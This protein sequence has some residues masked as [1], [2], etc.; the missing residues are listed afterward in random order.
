MWRVVLLAMLP[1][2]IPI[3]GTYIYEEYKPNPSLLESSSIYSKTSHSY[4][5]P[6]SGP[7][8]FH[9]FYNLPVV[10]IVT[11]TA[12]YI[13]TYINNQSFYY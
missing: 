11:S 12:C 8:H 13:I 9:H 4:E 6:P 1:F 2:L 10:K 3:S 5:Q 7:T